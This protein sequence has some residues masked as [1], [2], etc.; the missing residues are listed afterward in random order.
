MIQRGSRA[1]PS[2]FQVDIDKFMKREKRGAIADSKVAL[3][4][5]GRDHVEGPIDAPM[6]LLEYGDYECPYCGEAYYVVKALQRRLG[7][8]LCFAYRNFP[9]VN[10]H[11]HAEH[12]AE[13]AES[14]G[15]QGKFWE[16]HG[17]LFEN[18][19]ALD[20]QNI[21]EY[22]TELGLDSDRLIGEVLAGAH[23]E[24]IREDVQAGERANVGGTPT[25][26]INGVL[27]EGEPDVESLL[28]AL[29]SDSSQRGGRT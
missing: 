13:A 3:P 10:S 2:S 1:K 22:A 14:A 21:V 28:E 6:T 29:S 4:I 17:A 11:P 26:F 24:H 20:D 18:Q 12:A 19:G 7:H 8:R 25:F 16:M 9:L 23:I 5:N 27:F 15:D